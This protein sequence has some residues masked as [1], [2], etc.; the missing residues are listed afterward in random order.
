MHKLE[1]TT[2]SY[3]DK[4]DKD[5]CDYCGGSKYYL[6]MDG[7]SIYWSKD[8]SD[9]SVKIDEIKKITNALL[10]VILF[11]ISICGFL[12]FIYKFYLISESGNSILYQKNWEGPVELIIWV[13]VLFSMF[14]FY[15]LNSKD[16]SKYK[17]ISLDP[18]LYQGKKIISQNIYN[19][20]SREVKNYLIDAYYISKKYNVSSINSIS[21]FLALLKNDK[22]KIIL[23]RLG[24]SMNALEEKLIARLLENKDKNNGSGVDEL[25]FIMFNAYY[26]ARKLNSGYINFSHILT[27][28]ILCS[29]YIIELFLDFGISIDQINNVIEWIKLSENLVKRS[30][31]HRSV[32]I[33]KPR[34]DVNRAMT[35]IA[36]PYLDSFSEDITLLARRGYLPLNIEREEKLQEI[37]RII[38]SNYQSL[39]LLGSPGVG[40]NSII[41]SI[42]NN[43]ASEDV[44]GIL[45]DKR[46]VSLSISRFVS[47][48]QAEGKIQENFLRLMNEVI[49]SGNIVLVINDIH[50]MIGI[51]SAGIENLDLSEVFSDI[52]SQYNIM[53]IGT[54]NPK[55]YI[56]YL[57][58]SHL[59]TL[60]SKVEIV[61]P[62]INETI[63]ILESK[64]FSLEYKYGVYFS[65]QSLERIVKLTN[66]YIHDRH[67]PEKAI[68]IMEELAV[69]ISKQKN[70][71]LVT[72]EDV[73]RIISEKIHIPLEKVTATEGE[74]LL[75][76]EDTMHKRIVGQ[77][78]A[79]SMVASALRRARAEIRDEKKPITNLLFLG[80]TGVGKTELAKTVAQVFFGSEE[81]MI[82]LDMSEYQDENSIS[83]LMGSE[84]LDNSGILTEAVRNNPFSLV[85]LDEIEKAHPEI[86]NIFLQVMDDGRLTDSTGR[87]VDFS[88]CIIIATSNAGAFYIQDELSRGSDLEKIKEDLLQRE[89]RNYFKPEFINRFN[90]V[91][92]FKPLSQVEIE[93]IAIL[94][95]NKLSSKLKEKGIEFIA[96]PDA[97]KKLA[98]LG[99]S[100][101][102]GARPLKR[103]IE[104]R[105]NDAL[106]NF[107]L[108]NQIQRRDRAILDPDLSI[109]IEKATR[110]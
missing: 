91:V 108:T 12:L 75:K 49:R 19:T 76:L 71:R 68:R 80:P 22:S 96:S 90:G 84:N 55:D 17:I 33:F 102:F 57:E 72:S 101:D 60:L 35:A 110:L 95:L 52:I 92:L 8:L 62:N 37:Y 31:R 53:V 85:L 74:K 38:E 44:P 42:A 46:L 10:N 34:G 3:C 63:Q 73:S 43:M 87:T 61:E 16:N 30:K 89:L 2:I 100:K 21:L 25:S 29:E 67:Q 109:R 27:A 94:I 24:I 56:K 86:L 104:T 45:Q 13:C 81:S 82:R 36:T 105:V 28:D 77:N 14:L 93:Q 7:V 20:L 69:M 98:E 1:K 97:I 54:S 59:G 70:T 103:T 15:R 40:K 48:S 88:N 9:S 32:A 107:L 5:H 83:R 39:V 50:N 6:N 26:V 106:A 4:C 11:M 66:N 78:E 41:E 79:I 58:N 47:V 51:S 23:A 64:S 18:D 65:Y 99:F